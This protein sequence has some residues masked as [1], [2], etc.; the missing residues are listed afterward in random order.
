[1]RHFRTLRGRLSA[2][3]LLV[4][5]IAVA[6]LT[7]AFNVALDKSLD[8]DA[9]GRL[10]SQAAAAATTVGSQGGR[11]KVRESPNDEAIDG[12]IWVYE[13]RSAVLRPPGDAQLQR[14]ADALAGQ[15]GK[16]ADLPGRELRL[17]ATPVSPAGGGHGTVVAG[18]SL[19]PYERTTNLALVGSLALALV[20]LGA[21]GAVTWV[22]IGRALAPVAEMTR[23]A[24]EWSAHDLDRRFGSQSRLDELGELAA[25]FDRLLDRVAASLRHEQ[26][27]SAELSHE[28]RTPL[29]RIT[30]ELELLRRRQRSPEEVEEAYQA[31]ERST[32]QMSRIVDTL[33]AAARADAGLDR[34]RCTLAD[35]LSR[36][37]AAWKAPLAERGVELVV[38]PPPPTG[39]IVGVEAETFERILAPLLDNARRFARARVTVGAARGDG[40]VVVTVGDDG[41]GVPGDQAQTVF[42][43]G[44]SNNGSGGEGHRGAGLGLALARRLAR[45]SG[46]DLTLA[47]PRAGAG[48][49]FRLELP[50]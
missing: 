38:D 10:R 32:A 45:A 9:N 41:P 4:A 25:T 50:S 37:A 7:I 1:M 43:P 49:E 34:G 42:D 48:A 46:G 22:T 30:A 15:R 47:P 21:V 28:L 3:A 12:S 18:L 16:L 40:R 33:M 29:A 13:G 26:R 36:T 44:V 19:A 6:A 14:A 31:V 39:T 17:Y 35:G 27:L 24:D 2:L 8:S 23:S 5:A 11:L 20:L